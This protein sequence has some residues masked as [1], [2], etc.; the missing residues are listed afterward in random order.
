MVDKNTTTNQPVRSEL[1]KHYYLNSFV[2]VAPRRNKRPQQLAR[3]IVSHKTEPYPDI[4]KAP[5]IYELPGG[6]KPWRIKVVANLYPAYTPENDM[7]RGSQ[8]VI[9]ET[10]KEK[11][12]FHKL[13]VDE[14]AD[15]FRVYQ[16]RIVDLRRQYNYISIFKNHGPAS[17]AS[18]AHTHSQIIATEIIPPETEIDRQAQTDYQND[19][20][21][22]ALCDV[23]RWELKQTLRVVAHTR[24]TTT[25]CPYASRYPLE[26]WIIPNRQR[27]SLAELD[28]AETRSLAD[29]LKGVVMALSGSK[30]DYNFHIQEPVPGLSNHT[31]IKLAPRFTIPG[32]YE[33]NTDIYTNPVSPEYA[34]SWYRKYIKIPKRNAG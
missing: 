8:E 2:V 4:E 5:S 32:G 29:H 22:S 24:H 18:L 6:G 25:I 1:R 23:V 21:A 9:L 14:I 3:D 33:F 31:F 10:P 11:T 17:G 30:I 16:A 19:Y 13:S 12:P 26:A 7:A 27:Q 15:V 20:Q 28:D 34:T